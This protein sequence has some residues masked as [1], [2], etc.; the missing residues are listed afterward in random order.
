MSPWQGRRTSL[1]SE[2]KEGKALLPVP[3]LVSVSTFTSPRSHDRPRSSVGP[4]IGTA[5]A[6]GRTLQGHHC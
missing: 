6:S 1:P 2:E 5:D 3:F 4:T